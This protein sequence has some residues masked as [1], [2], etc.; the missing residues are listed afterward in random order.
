MVHRPV[1][2]PYC[3]RDQVAKRGK[4]DTGKQRYRCHNNECSHQS[5]VVFQFGICSFSYRTAEFNV[6]HI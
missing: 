3:Q 2:C 6:V 1:L 4:M 5:L